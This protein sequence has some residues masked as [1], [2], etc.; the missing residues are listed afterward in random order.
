MAS[1]SIFSLEEEWLLF[2]LNFSFHYTKTKTKHDVVYEWMFLG[3][4]AY[5]YYY[6]QKTN[7]VENII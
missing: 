3:V 7:R 5:Y 4:R 1:F 2:L 6:L